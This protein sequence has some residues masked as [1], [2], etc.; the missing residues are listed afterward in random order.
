[1][2]PLSL[3]PSL[4]ALTIRVFTALQSEPRGF[5]PLT[6]DIIAMFKLILGFQFKL[7]KVNSKIGEDSQWKGDGGR[8]CQ[9]SKRYKI[10]LPWY[11]RLLEFGLWI[12]KCWVYEKISSY[13]L[14]LFDR[15][16]N[17]SLMPSVTT[18]LS[19][20]IQLGCPLFIACKS[21][22]VRKFS[23][24]IDIARLSLQLPLVE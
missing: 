7:E 24:K 10:G 8:S 1:M 11:I 19:S 13:S 16:K 4:L 6:M 3:S 17:K 20:P 23:L 18:T 14:I 5:W 22:M 9:K 15:I 12:W 21:N 2:P